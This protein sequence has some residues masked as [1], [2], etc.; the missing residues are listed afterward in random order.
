M[1][2]LLIGISGA[3]AEGNNAVDQKINPLLLNME[4]Q[5]NLFKI[6]KDLPD[7]NIKFD[8]EN[9]VE[10]I[11]LT[12]QVDEDIFMGVSKLDELKA[13]DSLNFA[14]SRG[15]KEINLFKNV[16]PSVVLILT[17]NSIGSGALL[18]VGGDILTNNH[19]VGNNKQVLVALKP[20]S[21]ST[22]KAKDL[23]IADVVR[24][25]QTTDLA[26]IQLKK[27][28]KKLRTIKLGKER[29]Y[30]IGQDVHAIGHPQG[31]LWTYTKGFI[32]QI[33]DNYSWMSEGAMKHH[34][35]VVIQTQ[36]PINPGNSGGPLLDDK[37]KLIGVNSF[38]KIGGEGLNYAVS[39]EDV[40][41]FLRQ[42]G[43]VYAQRESREE[44]LSKK[45]KIHVLKISKIDYLKK[46]QKND[47]MIVI[48]RNN[49]NI[50]DMLA[51]NIGTTDIVEIFIYDKNE[52]G[53]PELMTID[54]T[55]S[56]K[57]NIY[58]TDTNKD[59]K[60]NVRGYDDNEDG[61][62]DRFEDI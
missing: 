9:L 17:K 14:N 36:T 38:K 16:A 59:G 41:K 47:T 39:I 49:N 1:F 45:L 53:K 10:N 34:A 33:R 58:L 8:K 35:R 2:L 57:P 50:A 55:K 40:K 12:N 26:L 60:Y 37:G 15:V 48:D 20:K 30:Q 31:N 32:S 42:E 11:Q 25:N 7:T 18:N 44:S 19:V 28:S 61:K 4:N 22:P 52:D 54:T 43:D 21:G 27:P 51:I 6:Y 24:I 62:I 46:G 56:G 23:L 3:L 5:S 29:S 13:K